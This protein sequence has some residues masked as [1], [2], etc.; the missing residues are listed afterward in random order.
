MATKKF[1]SELSSRGTVLTT[2]KLL[3]HN[4]TTG[5]TEYTTVNS[6]L[7][8]LGLKG[9]VPFPSTQV[10]STNVNTLD[11]YKE[12]TFTPVLE[13]GGGSVGITY[14]TQTGY[15]TKI[16]NRVYVDIYIIITSKGSSTGDA[17]I[18][19]LPYTVGQYAVC[20]SSLNYISFSNYPEFLAYKSTDSIY[21]R[22]VSA[23]GTRADMDNTNFRDNSI[24]NISCNYQV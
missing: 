10:P 4:I 7:N 8:A 18:T 6:L 1:P 21:L 17:I 22:Q 15:Y 12:G 23:A 24:I 14:S 3:I 5:D 2:D 9:Q 11:D 20:S 16:G 19:G 13:F